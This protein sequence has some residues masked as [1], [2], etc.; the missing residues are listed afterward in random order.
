ML[1]LL[2]SSLLS[3]ILPAASLCPNQENIVPCICKDLGDGPMMMC[4]NLTSAE[5]LISPIKSTEFFK[6]FSLVIINSALLYIPS[7]LFVKTHFERLRFANSQ[8]MSLSDGDLA[9]VG[10]EEILE[11]IRA[12]DARYITQWDWS[13]LK[14]LRK[15]DLIDIVDI[16][17]YSIDQEMPPLKSLTSLG[18]SKAEISFVHPTAFSKLE[19]LMQL[20]LVNNEI[21]ELSR[22]MLPDPASKLVMIDLS[23]NKLESL[24]DDM[25]TNMPNLKDVEINNNRLMTL[26]QE[27]FQW[28]FENLQSF[29]MTGNEIRCDCRLKWLVETR[30]PT[31]FKGEC[32][33]PDYM[34]GVSLENVNHKVLVC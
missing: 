25:F 20:S 22:A 32:S 17:M 1:F 24:P 23:D 15:L 29:M 31:Y 18:I 21:T 34:K 10:L 6:M 3:T 26:N 7:N 9:F 8:I 4:S 28:L 19:N 27:T 5:E 16:S 12:S 2:I 33:L 11:E 14:N 30:K 13:Q